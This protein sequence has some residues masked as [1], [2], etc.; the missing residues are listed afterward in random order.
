VKCDPDVLLVLFALTPEE[1]LATTVTFDVVV[2]TGREVFVELVEFP[3]T[4]T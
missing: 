4:T 1:L 3:E 2:L